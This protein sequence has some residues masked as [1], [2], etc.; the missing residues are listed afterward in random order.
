MKPLLFILLLLCMGSKLNAQDRKEMLKQTLD[1]LTANKEQIG[2]IKTA[3]GK[4]KTVFNY[5]TLNQKIFWIEHRDK[6]LTKSGDVDSE[7]SNAYLFLND[8]LVAIRLY[9][10]TISIDVS[11]MFFYFENDR[12]V[13]QECGDR[14]FSEQ[15]ANDMLKKGYAFLAAGY[16]RIRH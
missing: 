1:S 16:K 2:E 12:L 5:S 4:T 6:H 8:K 11:N 10:H 9:S 14:N 13:Q 3:K 15:E 7:T